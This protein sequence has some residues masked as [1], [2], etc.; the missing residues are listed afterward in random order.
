M[1]AISLVKNQADALVFL[2]KEGIENAKEVLSNKGIIVIK[3]SSRTP[4]FSILHTH[5]GREREIESMVWG[6]EQAYQDALA[7]LYS[8]SDDI[9]SYEDIRRLSRGKRAFVSKDHVLEYQGRTSGVK[10]EI[11]SVY[12]NDMGYKAVTLTDRRE[13]MLIGGEFTIEEKKYLD[14]R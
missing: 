1:V 5:N 6:E 12:Y 14:V 4:C 7:Y 8:L 9:T 2:K 3:R 11:V 13:V 10:G